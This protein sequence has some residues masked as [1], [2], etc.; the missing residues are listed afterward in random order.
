MKRS[1]VTV[2]L[3]IVC[4]IQVQS[5]FLGLNYNNT[6]SGSNLTMTYVIE[7]EQ[8]NMSFGLG[9]N[10]SSIR[11][12]DNENNIYF[13]R[14]FAERPIQRL[15][16]NFSKDWLFSQRSGCFEPFV[17]YDL[18][19]KH[20]VARSSQLLGH[21]FDSTLVV[22]NPEEGILFREQV[23]IFGPFTWVENTFGLGYVVHVNDTF[24][25]KQKIGGGVMTILGREERLFKDS[26]AFEFA[27]LIS[28]GIEYRLKSKKST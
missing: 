28:F 9:Y 7:K 4:A 27:G 5:Q 24:R 13:K 1:L 26:P 14:L 22:N 3:F 18:Q 25:I 15:N 12:P 11:Q 20:A 2:C 19:I 23:F 16:V 10:N 21:S 17:F 6:G 8:S